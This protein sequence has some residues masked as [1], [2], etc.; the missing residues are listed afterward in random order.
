MKKIIK[1][2]L[3]GFFI[4]ILIMSN[5]RSTKGQV[6]N[7]IPPSPNA[8][9]LA[10]PAD[11]EV[12]EYTG[13]PNISIPIY[14]I[15]TGDISLPITLNYHASGIKV[16]QEASWVGLGWSL[17]VGG[18][19]T[20]QIRGKDDFDT[21]GYVITEDL[22]PSTSANLTQWGTTEQN[23]EYMADYDRIVDG[24]LDGEP[25][26]FYYNFNSKSDKLVFEKQTDTVVA[27]TSLSQNNIKF[28]Y[29]RYTQKWKVT[30]EKGVKYFF[31]KKEETKNYYY[32][33]ET[34]YTQTTLYQGSDGLAKST[35][36]YLSRIESPLGYSINFSYENTDHQTITQVQRS[37]LFYHLI[38]IKEI[39]TSG[40]GYIS[41][42]LENGRLHTASM[43][44]INDV[45]LQEIS[46][47]GGKLT[48][49]PGDRTDMASRNSYKPQRLEDIKVYDGNLILL[50]TFDFSYSYFNQSQGTTDNMRLRLDSIGEIAGGISLPA[51]EFSYNTTNNLPS[52][53]SYS[54]DHW[55]FYNGENNENIRQYQHINVKNYLNN[56]NGFPISSEYGINTKKMMI[57]YFEYKKDTNIFFIGANRE[58]DALAMQAGILTKIKYPTGGSTE[59]EYEPNQYSS[60]DSLFRDTTYQS[61]ALFS[62]FYE[63]SD[64]E[65]NINLTE[66]TMLCLDYSFNEESYGTPDTYTS[67]VAVLKKSNGNKIVEFYP[68]SS[69]FESH[70]IVCLPPGQYVLYVDCPNDEYDYQELRASFK[71]KIY[72][73]N[74]IGGG[75]RIHKTTNKDGSGVSVSIEKYVYE[76]SGVSTGK[77]M[78][79][80]KYFYNEDLINANYIILPGNVI[81][82]IYRGSYVVRASTSC[83]PLGNSAQ[84]NPLGYSKVIHSKEST[85]GISNG[86][87]VYYFQNTPEEQTE[88]F[89]P[90]TPNQVFNNNGYA[91]KIEEYNRNNNL[92][93]KKTFGYAKHLGS[94]INIEGVKTY[95]YYGDEDNYSVQVRFYDIYSEWWRPISDTT[96]SYASDGSG[97]YVRTI[98]SYYYNNDSY[99][100]LNKSVVYTSVGDSIKTIYK[101]PSDITS[102]IYNAMEDSNMLKYPIEQISLRNNQFTGSTLTTYKSGGGS[103]VPDKVY[104]WETTSSLPSFTYFNGTTKDSNYGSSPEIEF[105]NY[106]SK[107]NILQTTEKNGI[108]TSYLWGYSDTYP[109]IKAENVS[110]STLTSAANSAAISAGSTDIT[111]LI[112]DIGYLTSSTQRT[113]WKNFNTALRNN[114]NLQNAIVTSYAYKPLVGIVSQSDPTGTVTYYTYDSF[115]RLEYIK[116]HDDKLIKRYGYHYAGQ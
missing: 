114:T 49:T 73:K 8:A 52:K 20:R 35:A 103:Y 42:N 43:Q 23:Y 116:D 13:I 21:G 94:D 110:Y 112:S 33:G 6:S 57:P 34:R 60:I 109:I 41:P 111:D 9:S 68:S 22:P 62:E 50:K 15:N 39:T 28:L 87:T 88:Y 70:I 12:S 61:L 72:T 31:E 25:D 16:E 18:C 53:T 69:D 100:L 26:L 89:M 44:E 24:F 84:G 77:L 78:S 113:K 92:I 19:I 106:S 104:S 108:V 64:Q 30:D 45:Y 80:L 36:W 107:G 10:L 58:P 1:S 4:M 3:G 51:Y 56:S 40:G 63:S 81:Q 32:S 83:I 14:T 2:I 98:N 46:F 37:E 79:P 97:N 102:T 48:F 90:G 5:T 96:Y 86:K 11:L 76:D 93:R 82:Y 105:N 17:N 27:A 7:Y 38:D 75:P 91:T 74:G 101:Y 54:M 71:K 95:K 47:A 55:G 65:A 85:T 115:G 99:R 59:F 66:N 29:D 67:A